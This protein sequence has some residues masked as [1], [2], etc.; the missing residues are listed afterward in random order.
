MI[1]ADTWQNGQN[2]GTRWTS[3]REK[4]SHGVKTPPDPRAVQTPEA[5]ARP[6]RHRVDQICEFWICVEA[7]SILSRKA[8]PPA[9]REARSGVLCSLDC[10]GTWE[11]RLPTI[12]GAP[13]P[14]LH[15]APSVGRP[16]QVTAELLQV[17][18]SRPSALHG[19]ATARCSPVECASV[20]VPGPV[21]DRSPGTRS[22]PHG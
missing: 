15:P 14:P 4:D 21:A 1:K 10:P 22:G 20:G 8:R 17:P 19:W 9:L 2:P 6:C 3:A 11:H 12:S 13:Q 7:G 5:E 16:S 18:E